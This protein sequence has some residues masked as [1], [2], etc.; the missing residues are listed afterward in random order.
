MELKKLRE[1]AKMMILR[2]KNRETDFSHAETDFEKVVNQ[3]PVSSAP[4]KKKAEK[5]GAK[6]KPDGG[7]SDEDLLKFLRRYL[8]KFVNL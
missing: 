3:K 5:G 6:D 7:S 2:A 1:R 8:S 4:T